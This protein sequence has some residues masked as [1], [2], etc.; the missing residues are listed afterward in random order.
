MEKTKASYPKYLFVCENQREAGRPCCMPEGQKI[1]ETLKEKIKEMGLTGK[2]RVS[3]TGC[4]DACKEGPNVLLMPD[5]VW[6][7]NVKVEDVAALLSSD[8]QH[9]SRP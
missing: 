9:L 5:H 4:L 1:R 7:K 3:R 8:A 6:F 2:I